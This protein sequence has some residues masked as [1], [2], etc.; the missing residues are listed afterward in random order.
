MMD[1]DRSTVKGMPLELARERVRQRLSQ[2]AVAVRAGLHE[3]MICQW[4]GGQRAPSLRNL[5]RWCAALDLELTTRRKRSDDESYIV[6]RDV[7][8][9]R[10]RHS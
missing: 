2:R 5:E 3:S 8:G 6:G 4:E 10:S 7:V 1:P 9:A